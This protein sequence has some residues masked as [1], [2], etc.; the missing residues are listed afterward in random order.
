MPKIKLTGASSPFGGLSWKF[1]K[2]DKDIA[3]DLI[4]FLE[5]RRVIYNRQGHAAAII[6]SPEYS[7]AVKSILQ[8]R[9]RLR[10]D[11][12][13]VKANSILGDSMKKMQKACRTFLSKGERRDQ[14][15]V[16]DEDLDIVRK[17]FSEAMLS[18]GE[19]F[20][21]YI[22]SPD[23]FGEDEQAY[24]ELYSE[25]YFRSDNIRIVSTD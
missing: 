21:F 18:I 6:K 2:S 16:Y 4:T 22:E 19:K 23:D 1:D 9:D 24:R 5:D 14:D 3:R 15:E 13:K 8:I 7:Y 20:G 10:E 17:E 11:L 25:Q 12:E